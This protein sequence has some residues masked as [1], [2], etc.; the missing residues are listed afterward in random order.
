MSDIKKNFI[1]NT[2]YQ[3]LTILIPIVTMPY[4]ARVIGAFGMGQYSYAYSVA[5]YYVMFIMLGLNNYGNRT[6]AEVRDDKELLSKNF[7]E[8]YT[9]QLFCGVLASIAYLIYCLTAGENNPLCWILGIYVISAVIDINWMFFGLEKFRFTVTR[10]IIIKI[11]STIAIF[12]LVKQEK[13]LVL[14]VLIMVISFL[15]SNIVLWPAL[16]KEV[17]WRKVKIRDM[18][19]HIKPNII[20]FIPIIAVSLYKYMDKIMLGILSSMKEVGYYEYSEKIIQ[21]PMSI[22]N[23]LAT[24]M[25]PRMSSLVANRDNKNE[26][27]YIKNSIMLAMFLSSSLCFGLMGIAR[28]FVAIFFGTGYSECINLFYVLLPSCCFIAFASVIRT[29][30]LIPHKYDSIYIQSVILGALINMIIN[31]LLIP[32]YQ[33]VGAAVGT[34]IAEAVVCIYQAYRVRNMIAM[35]EY[36]GNSIPFVVAGSVMFIALFLLKLSIGTVLVT[37]LIK[38]L[39]GIVFYFVVLRICLIFRKKEYVYIKNLLLRK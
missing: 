18:L 23:S 4:L 16:K 30:Y 25:L 28:E 10:N 7:F 12:C 39:V 21:I 9:M 1:Y 13:D 17:I 15:L 38:V 11:V 22:V 36:I 35:K 34:L 2:G 31:Y 33:S 20:L 19:K 29:Q 27:R 24:V 6:I 37:M 5:Y 26:V 14:Y 3:L 32:Q 8:I